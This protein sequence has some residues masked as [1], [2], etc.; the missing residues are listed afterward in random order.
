MSETVRYRI[1]QNYWNI[2]NPPWREAIGIEEVFYRPDGGEVYTVPA[3]VCWFGRGGVQPELAQRV[4]D[5]LN[6]DQE[7]L[8]ER[9]KRW[10]QWRTSPW[11]TSPLQEN[12]T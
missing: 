11:R 1:A 6:A 4:V 10:L 8:D 7:W 2:K 12:D 9:V 3:L 5:L